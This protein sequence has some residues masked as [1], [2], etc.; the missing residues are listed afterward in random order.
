MK[1]FYFGSEEDG[2]GE[3]MDSFESMPPPE[4]LAMAHMESSFV[5]LMELSVRVCEKNIVWR[6]LSPDDK[7]SMIRKVFEG[8]SEIEKG[9][10]KDAEIRD[11]M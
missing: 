7:L 3:D 4:F 6:L 2:E 8:I 11:E 9:Y 1:R 5:H 10:D